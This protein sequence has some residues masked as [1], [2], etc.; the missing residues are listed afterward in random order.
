MKMHES[1]PQSVHVP[2][3]TAQPELISSSGDEALA[4]DEESHYGLIDAYVG[5]YG[6]FAAH[7][8]APFATHDSAPADK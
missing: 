2:L 1:A 3:Q 6:P 8:S 7:D 5:A 4:S